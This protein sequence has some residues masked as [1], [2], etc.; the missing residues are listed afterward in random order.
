MLKINITQELLEQVIIEVLTKLKIDNDIPY[1]TIFGEIS[2]RGLILEGLIKTYP[3]KN[4]ISILNKKEIIQNNKINV[5]PLWKLSGN[6]RQYQIM[7]SFNIG[8]DTSL[9]K[10]IIHLMDVCGW[11]FVLINCNSKI[12]K[13]IPNNLN[14]QFYAIFEPKFDLEVDEGDMPNYCYH[15]APTRVIAKIK[16]NGLKPYNKGKVGNHPERL[17]LFTEYNENWKEIVDNFVEFNG[18]KEPYSYVQVSMKNL[19]NLKFYYDQNSNNYEAVFTLEPIP[20]FAIKI[21]DNT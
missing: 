16:N 20:N 13:T 15:I 5:S 4:V 3:I 9:F 2:N 8:I 6:K 1:E 21:I 7:L 10:E 17:Y 18:V 19:K 14:V 12:I 11:Y